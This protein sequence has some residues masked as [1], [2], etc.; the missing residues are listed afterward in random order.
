MYRSGRPTV[1]I[2]IMRIHTSMYY[3]LS[4]QRT[5]TA[6]LKSRAGTARARTARSALNTASRASRAATALGGPLAFTPS[7]PLSLRFAD[8]DDK[9]FTPAAKTLF[10][11][12]FYCEG[13]VRKVS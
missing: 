11:Y 5:A 2:M 6:T 10:E 9:L 12:V 7:A 3:Y 1:D 8:K 13:D 4:T